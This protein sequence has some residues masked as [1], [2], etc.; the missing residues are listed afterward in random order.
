MAAGPSMIEVPSWRVDLLFFSLLLFTFIYTKCDHLLV[1]YLEK[2]GKTGFLHIYE[3]LKE[4]LLLVGLLSLVLSG[5]P[6]PLPAVPHSLTATVCPGSHA[7][8]H[9]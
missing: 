2:R 3:A 4:E 8:G 7:T 1:K 6:P 5:A 9:R